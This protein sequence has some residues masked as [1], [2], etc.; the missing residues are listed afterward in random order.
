MTPLPCIRC[1]LQFSTNPAIAPFELWTILEPIPGHPQ[2]S[3][4][5]VNT[6]HAE[7]YT[8][9]HTEEAAP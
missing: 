5:S 9:I 2:H 7:G 4:L 3:T 1:G 6:L 8:P